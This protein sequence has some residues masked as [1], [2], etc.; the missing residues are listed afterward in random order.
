MQIVSALFGFF[1]FP[2]SADGT[3]EGIQKLEI[4]FGSVLSY[5]EK[6]RGLE[7]YAIE[8]EKSLVVHHTRA[9][10][11]VLFALVP[12]WALSNPTRV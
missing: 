6:C 9:T 7:C 4:C 11:S 1:S 8:M 5:D 2:T 10:A 3:L 12:F